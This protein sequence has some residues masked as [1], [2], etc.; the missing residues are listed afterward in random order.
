MFEALGHS[1]LALTRTRFGPLRL[2]A[3]PSGAVRSLTPR[4]VAALA[5]QRRPAVELPRSKRNTTRTS[6]TRGTS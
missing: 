4:E 1:V 2:A 6:V 5:H 3:L